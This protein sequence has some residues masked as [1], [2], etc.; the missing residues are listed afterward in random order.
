[1]GL[2]DGNNSWKDT[3]VEVES[4]CRSFFRDL[5]TSS[6]PNRE[7]IASVLENVRPRVTE[8]S[9]ANLDRLFSTVEVR[10]ALWQ[11]HPNKSLGPDGFSPFFF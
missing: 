9:K 1:M 11:V 3:Y 10:N 4:L 5:F 2:F 6:N 8:E 7:D